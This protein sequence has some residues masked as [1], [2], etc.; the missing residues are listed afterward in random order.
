MQNT[1]TQK[2]KKKNTEN[3]IRGL[4]ARE[5]HQE[6]S[7]K[8]TKKKKKEI[9][10]SENAYRRK[11]EKKRS[12]G[13]KVLEEEA[14]EAKGSARSCT[15]TQT[16]AGG[17]PESLGRREKGKSV[18]LRYAREDIAAKK[19]GRDVSAHKQRHTT[20]IK[21]TN[22]KEDKNNHEEGQRRWLEACL[23]ESER[24]VTFGWGGFTRGRKEGTGRYSLRG[25]ETR[26]ACRNHWQN[27]GKRNRRG[28]K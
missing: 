8:T 10:D 18:S 2:K 12:F 13:A 24:P 1:I 19:G 5:V 6:N 27:D 17:D 21:K 14:V 28:K 15:K 7:S 9:G 3:A 4:E 23:H 20:H 11:K 22:Q 26:K 25:G 16:R